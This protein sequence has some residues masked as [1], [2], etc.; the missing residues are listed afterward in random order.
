MLLNN[1]ASD[2]NY[3][4]KGK[5]ITSDTVAERLLEKQLR[6]AQNWFVFFQTQ[7]CEASILGDDRANRPFEIV[8]EN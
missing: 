2:N 5:T 8:N 6:V 1:R 7:A 3:A 4:L